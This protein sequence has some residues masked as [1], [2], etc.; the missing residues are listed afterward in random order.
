MMN[1]QYELKLQELPLSQMNPSEAKSF[2]RGALYATAAGAASISTVSF[3]GA[4]HTAANSKPA[5]QT[6]NAR[7]MADWQQ[8]GKMTDDGARAVFANHPQIAPLMQECAANQDMQACV[9]Q[10]LQSPPVEPAAMAAFGG[11]YGVL[12]VGALVLARRMGRSPA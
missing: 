3:A 9:T 7:V 6:A 12:A 11:V 4:W 10:Q 5:I 2:W 1:Q 8:F